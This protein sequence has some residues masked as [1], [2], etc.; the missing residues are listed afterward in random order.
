[1]PMTP[2][3][4]RFTVYDMMEAK[5][6]FAQN[7]ANADSMTPE[8]ARLYK[9][10]VEY[11]MMFYH[12]K[13]EERIT[14]PAEVVVTPMG[15]KMVGEQRELISRVAHNEEEAD[16]LREEGWH[17]HPAKAMAAAGKE[18]PPISSAEHIKAMEAEIERL[19]KQLAREQTATKFERKPDG[20]R[21]VTM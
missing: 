13:G 12:P 7:S 17:D 15:P 6:V 2:R 18:A 4:Q 9:G 14:R 16:K 21:K 20:D 5:G 1:M 11:P 3:N 10:P 19:R 8:G